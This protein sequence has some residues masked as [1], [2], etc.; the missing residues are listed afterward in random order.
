MTENNIDRLI[1]NNQRL[2]LLLGYAIG[3]L[4]L[5]DNSQED[6]EYSNKIEWLHRETEHIF[7][8]DKG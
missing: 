3:L 1:N 2:T 7:Y 8:L 4:R 5:P 6:E